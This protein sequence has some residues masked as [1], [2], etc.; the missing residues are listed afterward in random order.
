MSD[1]TL[2]TIVE[3][4]GGGGF[5]GANM[6]AGFIGGLVLGSLWNGNGFGFGG[7]R[8]QVGADVALA[9]SVEHVSDQ[10]NQGTIS[11]LQ[12]T[13]TLQNSINQNTIA[14]L[15]SAAMMSDKVSGATFGLA[16]Q[17]DSTGD[18]TVSAINNATIQAMQTAQGTNDRLCAINNNITTQGFEARL[19]N[20]ALASQLAEQ[21]AALSRQIYEENCKDRELAREIQTQ[22]IRDQLT[23]AQSQNAALNAQIN[24]T[25]QLTAQTAYLVN[26]LKPTTTTQTTA[27]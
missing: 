5:G 13:N 17:I 16:Q 26:Q 15:Q 6:G 2:P 8:G 1:M 9:N 27:G 10:V 7:N 4:G 22:A 23:Q 18:N 20:Q 14:S 19:Q 25:N 24:L 21:H 3:S 12:S 11:G